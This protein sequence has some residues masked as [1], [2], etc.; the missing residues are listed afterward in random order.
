[1]GYLLIIVVEV[2]GRSRS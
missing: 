2:M 1:V